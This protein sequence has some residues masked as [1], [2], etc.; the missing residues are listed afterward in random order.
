MSDELWKDDALCV[1]KVLMTG[2]KKKM[3]ESRL[4]SGVC[5]LWIVSAKDLPCIHLLLPL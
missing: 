4:N 5:D 2:E 1:E 3:K